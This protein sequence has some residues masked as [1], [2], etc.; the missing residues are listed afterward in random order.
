[1]N[2]ILHNVFQAATCVISSNWTAMAPQA[3][4]SEY[5]RA[6]EPPPPGGTWMW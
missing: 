5:T 3:L 1:M 6:I 2:R 4:A